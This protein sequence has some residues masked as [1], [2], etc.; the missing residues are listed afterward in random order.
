[1][2][3]RGRSKQRFMEAYSER[4]ASGEFCVDDGEGWWEKGSELVVLEK[5]GRW[6]TRPAA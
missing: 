3:E 2:A 5:C 6:L 4:N 1:L